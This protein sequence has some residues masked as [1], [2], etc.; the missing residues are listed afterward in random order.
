MPAVKFAV[1]YDC[2]S[3]RKTLKAITIQELHTGGK[4]LL[5]LLPNIG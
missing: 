1:M 3:L 5:Q 2:F 4:T